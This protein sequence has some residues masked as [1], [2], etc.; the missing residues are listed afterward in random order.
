MKDLL[1]A[2]Q[3]KCEGKSRA[4]IEQILREELAVRGFDMP[5]RMIGPTVSMIQSFA[6]AEAYPPGLIGQLRGLQWF[7]RTIK[8]AASGSDGS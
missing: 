8:A 5:E 1:A 4:E 2:V 6:E 7:L 3:A